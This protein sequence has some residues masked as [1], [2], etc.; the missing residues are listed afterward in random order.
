MTAPASGESWLGN[1]IQRLSRDGFSISYNVD[2]ACQNTAPTKH[3]AAFE[4]PVLYDSN[5]DKLLFFEKTPV[6]GGAYYKGF[7]NQIQKYLAAP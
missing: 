6:W 3:W 7:R 1:A 2:L 4:V 5:H